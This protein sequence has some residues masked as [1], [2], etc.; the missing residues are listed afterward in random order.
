M[1]SEKFHRRIMLLCLLACIFICADTYLVPLKN[2]T[3]VVEFE[4]GYKTNDL[5]PS[6]IANFELATNKRTLDVPDN[7][8]RDVNR[9]DSILVKCSALTNSVQ[10]IVVTKDAVKHTYAIGFV[11]SIKGELLLIAEI[12]G[13]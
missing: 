13:A 9:N 12:L 7:F 8:Y 11:R 4:E 3:E 2:S 5:H 6:S 10:K 1:K